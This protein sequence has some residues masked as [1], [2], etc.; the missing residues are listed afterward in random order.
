MTFQHRLCN[1]GGNIKVY[2][3]YAVQDAHPV[4]I[5][6]MPGRSIEIPC[7]MIRSLQG[8]LFRDGPLVNHSRAYSTYLRRLSPVACPPF[9]FWLKTHLDHQEASNV[10]VC[11]VGGMLSTCRAMR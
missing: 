9:F 4:L 2:N 11:Q 10:V 1:F 5:S 8:R 7:T 6:L 3:F